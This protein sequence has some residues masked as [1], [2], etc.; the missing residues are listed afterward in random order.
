MLEL[1]RITA[2]L[3]AKITTSVK[4]PGYKVVLKYSEH[5]QEAPP[6]KSVWTFGQILEKE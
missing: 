2:K 6:K 4:W 1:K 5:D 3:L